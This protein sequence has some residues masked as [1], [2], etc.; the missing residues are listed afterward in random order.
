VF[1]R[2]AQELGPAWADLHIGGVRDRKARNDPVYE[3]VHLLIGHAAR[4]RFLNSFVALA[5]CDFFCEIHDRPFCVASIAV[6]SKNFIQ[7]PK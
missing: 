6:A 2:T 3:I 4:L 1:D 5:A 7:Y